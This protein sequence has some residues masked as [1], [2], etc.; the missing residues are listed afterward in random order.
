MLRADE[1]L[2]DLQYKGYKIIQKINGFKYGTD[3]VLLVKFT[4]CSLEKKIGRCQQLSAPKPVLVDLGTGSGIM[5]LLL[6]GRGAF[7]KIS[8]L[9]IQHEYADMAAR[10]VIRNGLTDEIEIVEGDIRN[11]VR[12]YGKASTDC[13]I[14]NPPYKKAGSGLP[15]ATDSLTIARHEMLC[16][17][18]DVIAAAAGILKPRG[19][20]FMIHR[21]ERLADTIEQ[22]PLHRL[23]PKRIRFVYPKPDRAPSMFLIM[24]TKQGGRD[25][26]IEKPFLL[27]DAE[28]NET[29]ELKAAYAY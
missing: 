8:G 27:M 21:P 6:G 10:S 19:Y 16:R 7:R 5:P 15:N 17:L 25:L 11:A 14:T 18:E 22:M 4:L 29:E 1:Q 28:G 3:S 23:E 20:F 24:A 13:V 12:I 26:H 9:E 2:D